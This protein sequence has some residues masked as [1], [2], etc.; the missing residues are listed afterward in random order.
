[1]ADSID[2]RPAP[3]SSSSSSKPSAYTL[4]QI[5]SALD[6]LDALNGPLRLIQAQLL[7]QLIGPLLRGRATVQR[8]E[9]DRSASL[10]LA[11]LTTERSPRDILTDLRSTCDFIARVAFP[12][13][14]ASSLSSER[15][16]FLR[17][18]HD[19][20][21]RLLLD[22]L[23]LPSLPSARA[24]LPIWLETV[25]SA[26]H[27][28]TSSEPS[29]A[30]A[31][32][33]FY[34]DQAGSTWANAR[35]RKLADEVRTLILSGWQ[36][37]E[38]VGIGRDKE[39]SVVVEV[40]VED[41]DGPMPV[42]QEPEPNTAGLASS[43]AEA[44]S[45]DAGDDDQEEE[46]WGFEEEAAPK[47]PTAGPSSP[48]RNGNG[49]EEAED[50]WAFDDDL[51]APAPAPAPIVPPK[52]TR[53]AKKLGKKVAKSR[54]AEDDDDQDHEISRNNN[55]SQYPTPPA[56]PS[57][58]PSSSSPPP[59]PQNES[60]DWEA[61]DDEKPSKREELKP[62]AKRKELRE[63]S[64]TIKETFLVSKACETLLEFTQDVLRDAQALST[65]YAYRKESIWDVR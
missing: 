60:M 33:A 12:E 21:S 44:T 51:S 47:S 26:V 25:Q 6:R 5:Y 55:G 28:D 50:G 10:Q 8:D 30:R 63:E 18:L 39:I 62:K 17:E 19:S 34:D 16:R 61:W 35:R 9:N 11:P 2:P 48:S 4:S 42:A 24:E 45:A 1:M 53:E 37:W 31:V 54:Q 52:P 32:K 43:E 23:I 58:P 46:G 20:T 64:R 56:V 3:G 59:P 65:E 7:E 36:S 38:A 41:E 15:D 14:T 13:S 57:P 40:E 22:Y 29:G 49:L 27:F